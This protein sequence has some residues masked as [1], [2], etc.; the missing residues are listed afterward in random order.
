[1]KNYE[2]ITSADDLNTNNVDFAYQ[3]M[4]FNQFLENYSDYIE[5]YIYDNMYVSS[6]IIEFVVEVDTYD[7][8]CYVTV[9]AMDGRYT[10]TIKSTAFTELLKNGVDAG[11]NK[12][13]ELI[14]SAAS[15][16]DNKYIK[17]TFEESDYAHD[18]GYYDDYEEEYDDY[19]DE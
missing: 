12:I 16:D 3:T 9:E 1:M 10:Y 18:M 8:C 7:K 19:E 2:G 11:L 6:D 15:G 5:S 14:N 17:L 4:S 13:C